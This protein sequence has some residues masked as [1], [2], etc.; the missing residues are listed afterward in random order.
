MRFFYF[1][2]STI[3]NILAY[4]AL[5]F[6]F[7]TL[8]EIGYIY[9]DTE[10][11]KK[12]AAP[13]LRLS[14]TDIDYYEDNK[15]KIYGTRGGLFVLFAILGYFISTNSNT[16]IVYTLCLFELL[17]FQ[18]YNHIR[19]RMSIP[20]FSLLEI[21]KYVPFAFISYEQLDLGMWMGILALYAIP[22]TI[23]RLSFPRYNYQFFMNLLPSKKS[24]L[25]F[26]VLYCGF[27]VIIFGLLDIKEIWKNYFMYIFLFLLLF[28]VFALSLEIK[29]HI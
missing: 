25:Y 24:Y 28:R 15:I 29:K 9:N 23:E 1:H 11:T 8:Y 17:V 5:L 2:D 4:L 10:T 16:L 18:I 21:F 26:R 19:G 12:E 14:N 20:I 6:A 22:N 13:T 27:C 3:S 7:Y